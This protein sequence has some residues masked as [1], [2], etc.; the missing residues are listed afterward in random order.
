MAIGPFFEVT[1]VVREFSFRNGI[2]VLVHDRVLSAVT[3]LNARVIPANLALEFSVLALEHDENRI[4]V[5]SATA[6]APA[7][8]SRLERAT[9]RKITLHVV[10]AAAL[11][12][13]IARCYGTP[14]IEIDAEESSAVAMM[15]TLL[16]RAMFER[17][18]DLH[19]AMRGETLQVR[20]RI[21]GVLRTFEGVDGPLALRLVSRVKLMS[22]MDIAER[23]LPQDGRIAFP[24]QGRMVDIRVASLPTEIGERLALRFLDARSETL[25]LREL[26]MP[27]DILAMIAPLLDAA[28]GLFLTCGPTG[29][30]K[31]TT[32][33]AAL[34][35]IDRAAR[36]IC[37][38]EDPVE[39]R[40]ENVSQ[41]SINSRSG[42]SF[43]VALRALL[44]QDPDVIMIG[45]IRDQETAQTAVNAALTGQLVLA[46]VHSPHAYGAFERMREL[47][48]R[49][50]SL[51][52]VVS[53]VLAQRLVRRLCISCRAPSADYYTAVGCERCAHVG[54][55]GRAALFDVLIADD[56]L[57]SQVCATEANLSTAISPLARAQAADFVRDG[58]TTREEIARV[59][60]LWSS[61]SGLC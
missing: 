24:F 49:A 26:G 54:Y 47:G 18:S 30:G 27:A 53:G 33:Y 5:A 37:T 41:V 15:E 43:A 36:H 19:L 23:R 6:L 12:P 46:S 55:R 8:I 52:A 59:A 28:G 2:A 22:G 50:S 40:I 9:A 3:P 31:T 60:H 25:G 34:E 35:S 10:N 7:A 48:V 20:M 16:Q 44:R 21:D 17:A 42:L 57:R 61:G 58:V 4:V 32:L 13:E 14:H 1:R 45:E 39:R 51:A 38:V 29:S 11:T 56:R